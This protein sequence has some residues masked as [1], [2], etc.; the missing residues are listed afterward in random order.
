MNQD[1]GSLTT[2]TVVVESPGPGVAAGH[3]RRR[4]VAALLNTTALLAT[5]ALRT[6]TGPKLPPFVGD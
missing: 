6:T 5:T 2:P 1:L 4:R 3:R